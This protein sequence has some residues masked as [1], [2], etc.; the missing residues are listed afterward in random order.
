ME[1][2]EPVGAE[3]IFFQEGGMLMLISGRMMFQLFGD[4]GVGFVNNLGIVARE[5]DLY[6]LQV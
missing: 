2:S 4:Q 5:A 6:S 3:A 1:A